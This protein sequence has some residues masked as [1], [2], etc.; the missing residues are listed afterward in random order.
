MK[1]KPLLQSYA[2]DISGFKDF[3]RIMRI[4]LVL[5]FVC[6]LQ[7]SAVESKAQNAEIKLSQTEMTVKQLIASIEG[8]TD[9]LV[10]FRDLDVDVNKVLHLNKQNAKVSDFLAVL[11]DEIGVD[12]SI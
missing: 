7:L 12:L 2:V 8:Q 4:S 5:L 11:C 3:F 9:Y 1:R 10:V 6:A